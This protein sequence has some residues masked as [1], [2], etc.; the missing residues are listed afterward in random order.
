M[1]NPALVNN[2]P[3]CHR[4]GG[5]PV[6]NDYRVITGYQLIDTHTGN[7]LA[8]YTV[9]NRQRGRNRADRMD[10]QYG[11]HRYAC[12]PVYTTTAN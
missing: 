5:N 12:L 3:A 8:T 1:I 9:A 4:V 11:A 10:N 2:V 7:V 6:P